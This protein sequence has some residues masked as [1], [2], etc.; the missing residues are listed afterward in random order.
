MVAPPSRSPGPRRIK[1]DES[2]NGKDSYLRLSLAT[3]KSH[4]TPSNECWPFLTRL[5][6]GAED[7]RSSIKTSSEWHAILS[8]WASTDKVQQSGAG[9]PI[10]DVQFIVRDIGR[11][12]V[13]RLECNSSVTEDQKRTL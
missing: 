11:L 9:S 7:P 1:L 12:F 10:H 8:L 6:G 13:R 2:D 5:E 4:C 3:M